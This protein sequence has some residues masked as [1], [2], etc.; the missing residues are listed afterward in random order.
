M[1]CWKWQGIFLIIEIKNNYY[2]DLM[3]IGIKYCG[4]CNPRYDR[5]IEIKKIKDEN[6]Y[7]DFYY[8][9]EEDEYDILL[10]ACGCNAACASHENINVKYERIIL[11]SDKGYLSIQSRIK[12]ISDLKGT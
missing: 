1:N 2:G 10:V 5:A 12:A 8:A 11:T 3:K 4:G 9:N 7:I 6:K